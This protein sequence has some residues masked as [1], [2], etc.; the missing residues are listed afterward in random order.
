VKIAISGSSGLIGSA[1]RTSLAADGHTLL[2]LVSGPDGAPGSVRLDQRSQL[3]PHVFDGV[4]A[5]VNLAGA[6]VAGKRWT[7]AYKQSIYDSRVQTT[8][9]IVRAL[10]SAEPRP[11]VLVSASA[12]GYYGN[13]GLEILTESSTPGEDFL[14]KVCQDWESATV[15][16]TSAGIRVA[17][18]R[19]GLVLDPAG[20]SLE[21][22][23]KLTR[24][25]L[26]GRL[27]SGSQ[28]WSTLTLA[29]EVRAIRFLLDTDSASGPFNLVGP[30]PA[31]NKDFTA[32]LGHHLHR[33]TLL[34][35]P[36]FA[37][38][39]ALGEFSSQVLGSQR[40]HP[41]RLLA[42]GFTFDSPDVDS[43]LRTA[44]GR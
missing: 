11:R 20:G 37:I 31:T 33:P 23:L 9:N 19:T 32:A 36:S 35:V 25:G 15:P 3:D 26:G 6:P 28:Y 4:D 34:A 30:D 2:R 5:V 18:I 14:A 43:Q 7:S 29:D 10:Q 42:A 27:G 17:L 12:I 38:G 16:A 22:L 41:D 1:L 24:A 13:R 21:P 39:I 40:V 44:L 8:R